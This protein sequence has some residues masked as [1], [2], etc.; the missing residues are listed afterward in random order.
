M[1]DISLCAP[2]SPLPTTATAAA[3]DDDDVVVTGGGGGG[4]ASGACSARQL[5]S[6]I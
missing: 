2:L 1:R 6:L 4:P 5:P 3:A